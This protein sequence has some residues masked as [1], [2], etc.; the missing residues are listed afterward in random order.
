MGA[1]EVVAGG[2]L[3]AVPGTQTGR[4]SSWTLR[5][6]CA[7]L[8]TVHQ[9]VFFFITSYFYKPQKRVFWRRVGDQSRKRTSGTTWPGAGLL[10]FLENGALIWT[11]PAVE[12]T[13]IQS[14][15]LPPGGPG[16]LDWT[17]DV[18]PLSQGHRRRARRVD[19]GRRP[20][21]VETNCLCDLNGSLLLITDC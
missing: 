11:D 5:N 18:S 2:T 3:P 9:Y 12:D 14:P 4:D 21:N 15:I 20:L 16:F 10:C 7:E 13:Q 8:Q 19:C 6:T 17:V 1:A